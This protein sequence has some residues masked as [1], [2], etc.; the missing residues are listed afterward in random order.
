MSTNSTERDLLLLGLQV[1]AKRFGPMGV[2]VCTVVLDYDTM[3]TSKLLK[4]M[5]G[6]DRFSGRE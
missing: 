2:I 1:V 3:R 6:L 4:G 5:L